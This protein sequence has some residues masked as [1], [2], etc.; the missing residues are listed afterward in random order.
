MCLCVWPCAN[1]RLLVCVLVVLWCCVS[2]CNCACVVC[3]PLCWQPVSKLLRKAASVR[4]MQWRKPVVKSGKA[5]TAPVTPHLH[6]DARAKAHT[7]Q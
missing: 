2:V 7:T 5:P 3:L 4:S 1:V 6:T